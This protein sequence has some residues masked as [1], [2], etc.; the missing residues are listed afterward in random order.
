MTRDAPD[1]QDDLFVADF[2]PRLGEYLADG[3]A[4]GY[5][6]VAERTRFILWLAQHTDL[7]PGL[8]PRSKGDADHA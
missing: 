8:A 5:D 6:A 4:T 7:P 1:D 2:Y 3:H